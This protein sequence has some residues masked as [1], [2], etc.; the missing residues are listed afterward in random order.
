MERSSDAAG[1]APRKDR[2][3][4]AK[5]KAKSGWSNCNTIKQTRIKCDEQRPA[6]A[7]CLRSKKICSGYPPFTRSPSP[8]EAVPAAMVDEWRYALS[9][10]GDPESSSFLHEE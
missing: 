8:P 3:R 9:H 4:A 5:P 2:Q 6:C 1:D 7:N 10:D